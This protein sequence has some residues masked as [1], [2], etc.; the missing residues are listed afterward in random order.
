MHSLLRTVHC[1]F[2]TEIFQVEKNENKYNLSTD[3]NVD[4]MVTYEDYMEYCEQNVKPNEFKA[5]SKVSET[6]GG[7]LAILNYGKA[8]ESYEVNKEHNLENTFEEVV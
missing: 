2:S 5:D 4:N 1:V 7:N 3:S 6:E 8:I